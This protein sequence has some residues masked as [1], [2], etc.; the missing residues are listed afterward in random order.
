MASE[1]KFKDSGFN[2]QLIIDYVTQAKGLSLQES[3]A[4]KICI[5]Q[6]ADGKTLEIKCQTIERIFT[7]HDHEGES[8]LQVNF[9]D[10]RKILITR[11]LVGF[12]PHSAQGIDLS[13]IP[14]VVTTPDLVSVVEAIEDSLHSEEVDSMEIEALRR[15]FFSVLEGGERVGFDLSHEKAW[16]ARLNRSGNKAS[17]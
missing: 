15:L 17:A 7:R 2:T 4:E 16:L 6:N 5:R 13:K 14:N 3:D 9:F 8:F 12:R 11:S 10:G 1:A